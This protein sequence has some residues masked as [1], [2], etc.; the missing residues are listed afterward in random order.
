[1]RQATIFKV[2]AQ[3]PQTRNFELSYQQG[4]QVWA[5]SDAKR[6]LDIN[7]HTAPIDAGYELAVVVGVTLDPTEE[8]MRHI[9]NTSM[10][11]QDVLIIG[12]ANRHD[13]AVAT[14]GHGV[15]LAEQ[16][17]NAVRAHLSQHPETSKIHLFLAGPAGL[18]LMLGHRWNRLRPTVVYEHLG[19]GN[20]YQPAFA[21]D[22]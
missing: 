14:G 5:T 7:A 18:A 22:A 3:L 12:P 11:V 4:E 10:P 15:A 6:A 13:K 9:T 20:L 16:I 17:R 1:M 19:V 21:V 2:G 8:V